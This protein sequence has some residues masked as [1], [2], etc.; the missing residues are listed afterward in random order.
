[1]GAL[2]AAI[3]VV[4]QMALPATAQARQEAA[5]SSVNRAAT[6]A[7][8]LGGAAT[9]LALHEG[10]HVFFDVV[11]DAEES[12]YPEPQTIDVQ[13]REIFEAFAETVFGTE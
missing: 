2:T 4:A 3:A 9:G 10:A 13:T 7:V 6:L 8:F 1:M 11:F 12:P 5:P